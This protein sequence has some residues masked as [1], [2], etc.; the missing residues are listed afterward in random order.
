M[1]MMFGNGSVI[2]GL[3]QAPKWS[4]DGLRWVRVLPRGYYSTHAKRAAADRYS[5]RV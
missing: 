3:K 2:A 4:K 5:S 1:I